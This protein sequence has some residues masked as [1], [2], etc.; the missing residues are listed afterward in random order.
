MRKDT[1]RL[2]RYISPN[3]VSVRTSFYMPRPLVRYACVTD[4]APAARHGTITRGKEGG[5]GPSSPDHG[6]SRCS[7]W[8]V[9][10]SPRRPPTKNENFKE[11]NISINQLL[12]NHK[13]INSFTLAKEMMKGN[14]NNTI[15]IMLNLNLSLSTLSTCY[16]LTV[17]LNYLG[18]G[19]LEVCQ[20]VALP[21][22]NLLMYCCTSDQYLNIELKWK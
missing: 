21:G 11:N 8:T 2:L 17:W 6:C 15:K 16:F 5:K 14:Y 12:N 9:P 1:D 19:Y 7:C 10:P 13:I 3:C 18:K 4:S 22:R 20:L